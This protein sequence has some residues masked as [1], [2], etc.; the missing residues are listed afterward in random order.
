[1]S[2]NKS[3]TN[4]IASQ[5]AVIL[6]G[7][8]VWSIHYINKMSLV[9][10]YVLFLFKQTS[11][12][13]SHSFL[14]R[15]ASEVGFSMKSLSR[16]L[17]RSAHAPSPAPALFIN[18]LKLKRCMHLIFKNWVSGS[19]V[20]K[21]CYRFSSQRCDLLYYWWIW[22]FNHSVAGKWQLNDWFLKHQVT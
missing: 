6:I 22:Q 15:R 2:L 11:Q 12:R 14:T 1:M 19:W 5:L 13:V 20:Y 4:K 16:V 10:S 7:N 9:P 17:E 8:C 3:L 21:M 18:S